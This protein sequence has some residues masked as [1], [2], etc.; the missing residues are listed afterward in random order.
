MESYKPLP[1]FSQKMIRL[2]KGV[3]GISLVMYKSF[4][5][6]LLMSVAELQVLLIARALNVHLVNMGGRNTMGGL[7]L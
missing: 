2:K 7:D 4:I 5:H 1:P 3:N 6:I